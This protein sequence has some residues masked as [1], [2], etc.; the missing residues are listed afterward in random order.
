MRQAH[1]LANNFRRYF[2]EARIVSPAQVIR[3]KDIEL[4]S[5]LLASLANGGLIN[6]KAAV[7]RAIAG[8]ESTEILSKGSFESSPAR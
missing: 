3:M 7:D 1:K 2:G 4:V 5:E 6:K 8:R